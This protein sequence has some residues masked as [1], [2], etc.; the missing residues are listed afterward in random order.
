MDI[1]ELALMEQRQET[2]PLLLPKEKNYT[3]Q[4]TIMESTVSKRRFK[5][6]HNAEIRTRVM[7]EH[8]S[9]RKSYA[10]LPSY[11]T[12]QMTGAEV[13]GRTLDGRARNVP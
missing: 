2:T 12:G 6:Y 11:S 7:F 8:C 9:S 3:W 5:P 4:I 10:E 13:G 1:D